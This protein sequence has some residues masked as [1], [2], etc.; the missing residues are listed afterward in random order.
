[1]PAKAKKTNAVK[2]VAKSVRANGRKPAAKR[3]VAATAKAKLPLERL[4]LIELGGKP[5]T[6]V[7]ED[8][9]VGQPSPHFKNQ[10]GLWNGLDLWAE[11]DPLEATKGLV[12]IL[13][14]MP[15]LDTSVCDEETRHFN[16]EAAALGD[17]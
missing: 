14:A 6:V 2:K 15:S 12:R 8:V 1:M 4:G 7:G 16:Q 5:A 3:I 11:V 10:V 17:G 9:R 13:L